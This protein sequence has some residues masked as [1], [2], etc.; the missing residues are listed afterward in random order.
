MTSTLVFNIALSHH[1][2]ALR[3]VK[4]FCSQRIEERLQGCIQLYELSFH[5]HARK[6]SPPLKAGH[7]TISEG[8]GGGGGRRHPSS[9]M[10]V[11]LSNDMNFTLALISNCCH[12]Y[13]ILGRVDKAKRYCHHTLSSVMMMLDG[14]EVATI[15]ELDGLL[16]NAQRLVMNGHALAAAA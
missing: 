11:I 10:K 16:R 14:G 9:S 5:M 3:D 8:G 1:L 2:M 15:T 4:A 13:E 7:T 6:S 12:V